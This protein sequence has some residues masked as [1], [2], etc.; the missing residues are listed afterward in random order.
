MY[1]NKKKSII[2]ILIICFTVVLAYSVFKFGNF[3]SKSVNHIAPYKF[4][5]VGLMNLTNY[6]RSYILSYGKFAQVIFLIIYSL[7]PVLIIIPTSILTIMAGSIF[8]PWETFI[9]SMLGCF[10]SGSLAFII[11]KKIGKPFVDRLLKGKVISLNN[12]VEAQGFFIVLIMRLSNV[13]A[14]DPLSY[15]IGL[16]KIKYK[17][18]I[19]ATMIGVAPEILMYSF[20]SKNAKHLFSFKFLF[21]IILVIIISLISYYIYTKKNKD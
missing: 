17:H 9:L 5:H 2:I 15:A 4:N 12:K 21:P 1:N 18:F 10:F 13:F 3:E 19:L 16:T 6:I 7:K 11:A 8:G 14:Y 20:M